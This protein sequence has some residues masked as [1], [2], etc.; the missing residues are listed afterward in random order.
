M[1][2]T[3]IEKI[4]SKNLGRTV[5]PGEEDLF[6]PDLACAYD[7]PGWY[8]NTPEFPKLV[9]TLGLHK[10]KDPDQFLI[11]I[12]HFDPAGTSAQRAVHAE[13]REYCKKYGVKLYEGKGI[14]HQVVMEEGYV[15]PGDFIVH[16]DTHI[17][18]LGALG[19]CGMGVRNCLIEVMAT[20][21]I[22]LVVPHTVRVDLIGKMRKGVTSRDVFNAM[23]KKFGAS[24]YRGMC[25]EIG[26]EGLSSIPLDERF[27][28]CNLGLFMSV[29]TV[30]MEQ[31]SQV[32]SFLKA[33]THK[34]FQPVFPD[35]NAQY[36]HRIT[37][38]LDQVEPMLAVPPSA[39]GVIT[40]S[41]KIGM[42]VDVG[43]VGSCA[44]GRVED[45]KRVLEIIDGRKI[46]EG[47]RLEI[48]PCSMEIQKEIANNG[49]MG[50]LI[51]AGAQ[52]HYPS[53]DTCF[54]F[55]C[56]MLNGEVAL[57]TGTLNGPGRMGC[58]NADIYTA[59]TYA[60]AAAS[61]TGEVTDPRK[62]L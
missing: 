28:F 46:K 33:H 24:T 49:M 47:F 2:Q 13:T 44:S 45:F 3:I 6:K 42:H 19:A 40:L 9:N 48:I 25:L 20:Q 62:Y 11:F 4:L 38:D 30:I 7:A 5:S 37:V 16:Y 36:A 41:E 55:N 58:L 18:L 8:V 53:C 54:G 39:T 61:L 32:D 22:A 27:T 1:G 12:D 59:S 14:G 51:D 21:K 56:A 10:L 43:Y 52:V 35:Y 23:L 29:V 57:S 34:P 60:I 31:D 26:G 17:S 50:K 15:V